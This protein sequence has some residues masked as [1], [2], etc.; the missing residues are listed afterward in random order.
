[1]VGLHRVNYAILSQRVSIMPSSSCS[2][3]YSD[4][5]NIK[6]LF[7]TRSMDPPCLAYLGDVRKLVVER[8]DGV[9][10]AAVCGLRVGQLL[11]GSTVLVRQMAQLRIQERLPCI[12]AVQRTPHI[13]LHQ[14]GTRSEIVHRGLNHVL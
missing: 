7:D 3:F 14:K 2:L 6:Q 10:L 13:R 4:K 5:I 1:M 11:P 8:G 9:L 12:H